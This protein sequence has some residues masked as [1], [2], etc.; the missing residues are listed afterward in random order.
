MAL[1]LTN[2]L[3][4]P[5]LDG[6]RILFVAIELLRG[7]PMDPEREGMVHLVGLFLLLGLM[8]IFILNDIVNPFIAP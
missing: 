8:G 4:I 6:G 2:L 1:G 7:K 5:G 3:P